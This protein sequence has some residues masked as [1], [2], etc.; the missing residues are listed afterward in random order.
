MLQG[1]VDGYFAR[2]KGLVI[3]RRKGVK[4]ENVAMCTDGRVFS[5]DQALELGLVDQVG[6]IRDAFET[7]K[8]LAGLEAAT[9]VKY[10]D[11]EHPARTAYTL[12][13]SCRHPLLS[14]LRASPCTW[15]SPV[16]SA[17]PPPWRPAASITSGCPRFLEPQVMRYDAPY[18]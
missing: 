10:S 17:S 12:S 15:T 11:K 16:R 8:Q 4:P 3:E 18:A 6:G 13:A 1:L 5:G 14:L 2:F 9:L 7:A